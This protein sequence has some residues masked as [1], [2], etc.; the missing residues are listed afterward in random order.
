MVL[1]LLLHSEIN[2]MCV[3]VSKWKKT[4][5]TMAEH[6][7]RPRAEFRALKDA[8]WQNEM[9]MRPGKVPLVENNKETTTNGVLR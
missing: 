7:N 3:I 1:P 2:L 9:K 6:L 5:S 4:T 8:K